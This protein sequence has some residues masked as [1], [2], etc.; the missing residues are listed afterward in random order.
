MNYLRI[1]ICEDTEK[2][3]AILM[4]LLQN[5]SYT[6][7][8]ETFSCGEDFL[9]SFYSGRYDLIL[10]DI[11]MGR[12]TGMDTVSEIRKTDT[13]VPIA[14]LTTSTDHALDSYRFHVDRY[15]L[16]P[17]QPEMIEEVLDMAGKRVMEQPSVTVMDHG[18]QTSIPLTQICYVEQSAHVCQIHLINHDMVST[19]M[20]LNDLK[21]IL[22]YPN[23]YLCHKSFLVNLAH[24]KRLNK[25][26]A[27]FEMKDG[28]CAYIRRASIREAEKLC[29]QYM[30][31]LTRR[32]GGLS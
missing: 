8:M 30:F 6:Y 20:K 28:G 13:A 12:L 24:V 5:S 32:L 21:D 27:L 1:G 18:T 19:V 31:E 16:K 4:E 25:E 29:H 11:Y 2:D 7:N 9:K 15:I 10:M 23:F 17:Y 3:L 14:F 22:S 26:L